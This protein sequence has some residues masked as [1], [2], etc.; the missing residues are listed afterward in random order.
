M[1]DL[2][3]EP[4]ASLK[5]VPL[6]PI[7]AL[8]TRTTLCSP[9][10]ESSSPHPTLEVRPAIEQKGHRNGEIFGTHASEVCLRQDQQRASQDQ[11]QASVVCSGSI[12]SEPSKTQPCGFYRNMCRFLRSGRP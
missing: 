9:P 11:G 7:A 1:A 10:T 3:L 5:K 6:P 12:A 8:S 2:P 4:V